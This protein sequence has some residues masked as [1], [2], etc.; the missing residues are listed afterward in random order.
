MDKGETYRG[1]VN[2]TISGKTCE[3]WSTISRPNS[4]HPELSGSHNFCRNPKGIMNGPWCN[5][6][7]NENQQYYKELCEVPKCGK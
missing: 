3:I 5:V 2:T 1:N 6:R 4:N 7:S